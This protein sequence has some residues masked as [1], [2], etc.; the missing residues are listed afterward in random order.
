MP[1]ISLC[2]WLPLPSP[3]TAD[4]FDIAVSLAPTAFALDFSFC[5]FTLDFWTRRPCFWAPPQRA[6]ILEASF[7]F[8]T[9]TL[10]VGFIAIFPFQAAFMPDFITVLGAMTPVLGTV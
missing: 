1:L 3:L 7:A 8:I 9:V 4:A 6:T 10:L 2:P 5:A